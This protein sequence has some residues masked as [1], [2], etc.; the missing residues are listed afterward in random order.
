[1][2]K[3]FYAP[4]EE[5]LF[6][7]FLSWV[8]LAKKLWREF[9]EEGIPVPGT[10]KR[11]LTDTSHDPPRKI[12]RKTLLRKPEEPEKPTKAGDDWL[13]LD[14]KET[15]LR[16]VVLAILNEGKALPIKEIISRVKELL[17]ESNEGSIYNLGGQEEK[18][19]K[20]EQGWTLKNN[21]EAPILYKN[22]IWGSPDLL[23]KQDLAAFRRMVVRYLLETSPDG[24]QIMQ[25]YRQL[26][27]TDWLK[28][29]P[30]S[31]DLVKADLFLMKKEKQANC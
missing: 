5:R 14:A 25:I 4:P 22:Y 27:G 6:R 1:M 17:P 20:T 13:W 9:E 18:M 23:Q 2:E 7:E 21:T 15:S 10:L 30:L 8:E 19:Q 26:V 12:L 16:T 28:K 29:V 11:V 24:L 3:E 31:K